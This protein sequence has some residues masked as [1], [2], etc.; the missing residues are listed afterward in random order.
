MPFDL[1]HAGRHQLPI[2]ALLALKGFEF[3][4][5]Q[6]GESLEV[7][8][9]VLEERDRSLG[10]CRERAAELSTIVAERVT[11]LSDEAKEKGGFDYASGLAVFVS[12]LSLEA[13]RAL[14]RCCCR[15]RV[16]RVRVA[17]EPVVLEHLALHDERPLR[18]AARLRRPP[19]RGGGGVLD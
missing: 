14:L 10:H 3:L 6:G 7:L 5:P 18:Q 4:R 8:R 13:L 19:L 9:T 2:W 16:Q 12:T 11:D 17:T 15:R 1:A